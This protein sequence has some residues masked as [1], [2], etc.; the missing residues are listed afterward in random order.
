M[1]LRSVKILILIFIYLLITKVAISGTVKGFVFNK[2]TG[3]PLVNATIQ[4]EKTNQYTV[5]GL[6]GSF[7]IENVPPGDYTIVI[8]HVSLKTFTQAIKIDAQEVLIIEARLEQDDESYLNE[9]IVTAKRNGRTE[10]AARS[11]EQYAPQIVNVVSSQAI[12]ISPDLTAASIVKRISGVSIERDN[13]GNEQFAILRG[14]DKRYNYTLING[15]KI[16]SPDKYNRYVPLDIFP[17]ELLER[18]EVFKTLTP[19]MEGDAIGGAVNMVM[20]DA[21]GKPV[22]TFNIASGYND[23]FFD[24]DFMSFDH[25]NIDKLS[26]YQTHPKRYNAVPSDFSTGPVSYQLNRPSPDLLAGFS[27]GNRFFKNK[28]GVLVSANLQNTYRGNNSLFFE[29]SVVDTLKGVTL[30]SMQDRNYSEQ[31]LRYAFYLKNDYRLPNGNK[32]QWNN[33]FVNLTDFQVRDSKL[34]YLTLGGYDP[35]KGNAALL[36]S[37]RSRTTRQYIFNSTL[38]G[39]HHLSQDVKLEWSAVYSIAKNDVPDN[40]KVTLNGEE[41]NFVARKTTAKNASRRW[42]YNTDRDLAAYL[43]LTYYLPVASL[44]VE[45]MVGGLYRDK[46]RDNFYNEY[47][48]RP[49]DPYDEY[50]KDFENYNEIQWIVEN[51][52]G[53]VGTSLNYEASEKIAAEFVQ[54]KSSGRHMEITGGVRVESTSQGYELDYPIGEN[55]PNG[56]QVYTDVLPSIHLK[57]MPATKINIRTSY[58]RSI[59]RPGFIEITPYTIVNED[60]VERGNPDLKHAVA[61]NIDFRFEIFP[62]PAEQLMAGIFYKHIRDP[63]E[64]ILKAD[65]LRGQDIYYS[66]GNF[67]NAVNYGGELD[68]IKYYNKIGFKVN[69][70]YT[71]SRI[72]TAKSKRIRDE[73][74]NLKTISVDETRSLY[75]QSAHIGNVSVLYKDSK[76]GWDAQLAGQY[77]GD[78]INSVSQFVGNDQ[79]QKTFIQMDASVEKKFKSRLSIFAKANNLLN[80]PMIVYI[81]NTS[82][83]NADVPDQSLS[84]KTL[85]RE[86][87]F[88][89]SYYLGLRY[90]W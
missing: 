47:Y 68:F 4:L 16:P 22:V 46:R 15:V 35:E 23:I 67:G 5:S 7:I 28:L 41:N 32:I 80:T 86:N 72:T 54:F 40:A 3:T 24:R 75:G 37:T 61:D 74:G 2:A 36:Y 39:E 62:N 76:T 42:E 87:Y 38:Q 43:N 81:D 1:S 77:T 31:E 27:A 44:P 26:P 14:M 59:N 34:T 85:I 29:S 25:K 52:R 51:P 69:Y 8:N 90:M 19:A 53:S 83:K 65:S 60:Y 63:I 56:K 55:R 88:Q 66:P 71:H 12:E 73:N 17:S 84:G 82:P 21:P 10:K 6:N 11:L 49:V 20:K 57:Y 78:R 64:Y 45:W 50:G 18:V 70:T 9:V 30:T 33:S 48:F 13:A 58:F 79:W 89:R